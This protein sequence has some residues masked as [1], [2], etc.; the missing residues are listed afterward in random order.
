MTDEA[1]EI[2]NMLILGIGVAL[3]LVIIGIWYVFLKG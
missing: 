3:F 1:G 2:S